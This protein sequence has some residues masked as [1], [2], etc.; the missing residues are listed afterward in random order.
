MSDS[1][2]PH[3][4][5][6]HG[7]FQEIVLEW[8]AISFSRYKVPRIVKLIETKSRMVVARD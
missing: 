4:S 2:R 6:V 1:L 8:L 3:G 5:S 7:I